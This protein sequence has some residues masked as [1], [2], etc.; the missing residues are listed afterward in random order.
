MENSPHPVLAVV[1]RGAKDTVIWHVQSDPAAAAILSGAWIVTDDKGLLT[2]VHVVEVAAL[3][4]AVTDAVA[5]LRAAAKEAKAQNSALKL[6]RFEAL[7]LPDLEALQET[8]HG[9]ERAKD[10]WT[11]AITLAEIVDYWHGVE[12]ARRMR[13]YLVD[14]FGSEVRPIPLP[15]VDAA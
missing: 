14:A 9:E 5:E 3:V 8:F 1:D 7:E 11:Q 13:K 4:D 15:R 12:S 10:A 2:D 6:P